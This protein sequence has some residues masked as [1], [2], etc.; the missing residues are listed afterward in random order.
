MRRL[1]LAI[2]LLCCAPG[3]SAA[4]SSLCAARET[5]AGRVSAAQ[6][7][8]LYCIDLVPVPDLLSVSGVAE[9]HTFRT[10]AN[11]EPA[12]DG[13]PR[14]RLIAYVDGLPD[15]SSL[16][17]Y[18]VF[19]AWATTLSMDTLIRLG[20]VK[21][22]RNDLGEVRLE[23]FRIMISAES[24]VDAQRRAG[25]FVLRGTSPGTR[26]L[27]HRDATRSGPLGNAPLVTDAGAGHLHTGAVQVRQAANA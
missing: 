5:P 27:A 10:G 22:G 23:Q 13:N 19:V 12:P 21:R 9:L 18:R 7:G 26:L 1:F 2:I 3:D 14:Y 6:A 17:P 8:S 20:E 15:P 24:S 4:Q 11:P 16:G 25:P